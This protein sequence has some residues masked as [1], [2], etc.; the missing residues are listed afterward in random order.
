MRAKV[1]RDGMMR[2]LDAIYPQYGFRRHKGYATTDHRRRLGEHGP[3][4][5]HRLSFA[6][7]SEMKP[8]ARS[9]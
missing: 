1:C 8:E 2:R 3:C 4:T 6:H 7:I 9:D 5:Q